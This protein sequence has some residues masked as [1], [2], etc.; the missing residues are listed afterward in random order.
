MNEGSSNVACV[1]RYPRVA[2]STCTASRRIGAKQQARPALVRAGDEMAVE[3]RDGDGS[4]TPFLEAA[5][6]PADETQ[7]IEI[8][9]GFA[10]GME[11]RRWRVQMIG[12]LR[13]R[14][15]RGKPRRGGRD[16]DDRDE[17]RAAKGLHAVCP[18]RTRGSA[19]SSSRSETRLPKARNTPPIA[20][21]PATR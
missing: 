5:F 14:R 19:A 4:V 16:E 2:G 15:I 9:A 21:Q 7:R 1:R 13:V 10:A 11:A 12:E 20:A 6:E 3:P 18:S 17:E 8:D